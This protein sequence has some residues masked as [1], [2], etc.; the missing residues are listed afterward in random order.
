[1]RYSGNKGFSQTELIVVLGIF[2]VVGAMMALSISGLSG[3]LKFKNVAWG[4]SAEMR[5]AKQSASNTNREQRVEFG[6][7]AGQ[8]RLTQGNLP[9]G[10]TIWTVV[11]PWAA[12]DTDVAWATGAACNGNADI[13]IKFNPNGSADAG[14]ICVMDTGGAVRYRVDVSATSGRITIN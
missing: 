6:I 8:Y 4:I 2:G 12:L 10:S 11:K 5:L 3:S 9:A 13:N 7:G 1:M 14:T